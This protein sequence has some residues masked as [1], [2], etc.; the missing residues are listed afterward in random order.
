MVN[1]G[2]ILVF[3]HFKTNMDW[4]VQQMLKVY[5]NRK[6][7]SMMTDKIFGF[8]LIVVWIKKYMIEPIIIQKV[9]N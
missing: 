6:K 3:K 7:S 5:P 2:G 4:S 9:K 1:G 8:L